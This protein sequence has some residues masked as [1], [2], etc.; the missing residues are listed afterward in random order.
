MQTYPPAGL[1]GRIALRLNSMT[2]LPVGGN[3]QGEKKG[4]NKNTFVPLCEE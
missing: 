1:A 2:L 4:N 3:R